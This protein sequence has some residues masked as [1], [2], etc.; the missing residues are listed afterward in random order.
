MYKQLLVISQQK[1]FKA[2]ILQTYRI[3][4]G[5]YNIKVRLAELK[6][7]IIYV[8]ICEHTCWGHSSDCNIEFTVLILIISSRLITVSGLS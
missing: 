6:L 3:Y 1:V 4:K 8:D 5:S 7:S 2:S